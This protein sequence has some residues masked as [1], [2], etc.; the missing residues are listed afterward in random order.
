ML[1]WQPLQGI[2]QSNPVAQTLCGP[3]LYKRW[4]GR[5]LGLGTRQVVAFC[6]ILSAGYNAAGCTWTF[7]MSKGK[8]LFKLRFAQKNFVGVPPVYSSEWN[9][10]TNAADIASRMEAGSAHRRC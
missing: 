7:N 1:C 9:L 3:T 10:L 8:H 2:I 4:C 6:C 5:V